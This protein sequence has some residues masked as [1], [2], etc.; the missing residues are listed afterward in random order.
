MIKLSPLPDRSVVRLSIPLDASLRGRLEAYAA[1]YAQ[2]Y[3]REEKLEDL[4]PAML[5]AFMDADVAFSGKRR[6]GLS[7]AVR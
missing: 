1:L 6:P 3:G 4:V 2:T 7:R 5:T